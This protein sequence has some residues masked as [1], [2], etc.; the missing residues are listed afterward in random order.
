MRQRLRAKILA[1]HG[2]SSRLSAPGQQDM[3]LSR[4]FSPCTCTYPSP[5]K[6]Q[7]TTMQDDSNEIFTFTR[8]F[9]II[10]AYALPTPPPSPPCEPPDHEQ[11]TPYPTRR[12]VILAQR[13]R[14][15]ERHIDGLCSTLCELRR[16]E[17]LETCILRANSV[18]RNEAELIRG[19]SCQY[20]Q[21]MAWAAQAQLINLVP[22]VY[23]AGQDTES[24]A[25]NSFERVSNKLGF[26]F[27]LAFQP[28]CTGYP[29][30]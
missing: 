11:P 3:L 9:P 4:S 23:S 18:S 24:E 10:R 2:A 15:V 26:L 6:K 27:W 13:L 29:Q 30:M 16:R 14:A 1:E 20:H 12:Q 7:L 21:Q 28:R 8:P 19:R 17:Q 22:E 5:L 25:I